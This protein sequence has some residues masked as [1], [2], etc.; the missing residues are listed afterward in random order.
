MSSQPPVLDRNVVLTQCRAN[1][2]KR[3]AAVLEGMVD[4]IAAQL[5]E[6][7]QHAKDREERDAL[8]QGAAR[9]G[10]DRQAFLDAFRTEFARRFEAA[11]KALQG[12]GPSREELDREQAAMLKTN[13]LENEVAVIKLSVRLKQDAAAELGELSRRLVTLFRLHALD[14][15]DNPL[16][17]LPIAHAVF[18]GF[19]RARVEGRAA[20]A[21][22]PL[23]EEQLSGPV[24]ELYR[25]LNQLLQALGVEP[26]VPR[27]A[28]AAPAAAPAAPAPAL[29][30]AG[31]TARPAA[32]A[33]AA[34]RATVPPAVDAFL[35]KN[36]LELLARTH[37]AQGPEG[38]PWK[39][40]VAAMQYLVASLK[41]RNDPAERAKLQAAIPAILKNITVGMDALGMPPAERQPVLD[42]LMAAHREILRG[43]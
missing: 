36:W 10:A 29:A 40:T 3:L 23:V 17:P 26:N 12:M 34:I 19:A 28:A 11:A 30:R 22:R 42:A 27:P 13:V 18:A 31:P 43:K 16:G 5:N 6:Q 14:D 2:E 41:P 32:I 9:L 8:S 4:K 7:A 39:Q 33:A 20:R 21:V 35:R 15:G 37:A 1:A 25:A 24:R 38:T